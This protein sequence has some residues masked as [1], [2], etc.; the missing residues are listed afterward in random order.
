M[1]I[2]HSKHRNSL[3]GFSLIELLVVVAMISIVLSA[4]LTQVEQVQQRATAEQGK[5]NDFEQARDFLAQVIR[6]AR[7]MGYPNF[8][9]FDT[10]VGTWQS[11]LMN[12]SRLAIGLVKL[13]STQ[14]WFEG[15]VN[16]SG[17]VSVVSYAIN[18]D[19]ACAT[20]MER[21]QV[22]KVNGNPLTAQ[23]N[24]T[25]SSYVQ[26]V[27]NVQNASSIT[28]PVFSAYDAAGN[29]ITLP[30]NISTDPT[31]TAKVRLIKI[32]LSV[33]SPAS[34]DPRTGHQL[35]ADISG[36]VQV[37]NCSMATTNIS[38]NG[39]LMTCQ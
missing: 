7:Q 34:T 6:D 1:K 18:G 36:N 31:D 16:S 22:A 32:N 38:V 37:V 28:A 10:T 20:C 9:N 5:V 27:Q 35:E 3:R 15:D 17:S 8:H 2:T 25:A 24:L 23:T 29:A 13:T 30:V 39:F 26:E 4:V 12:D 21:A 19:G 11:P 14:L 33:A